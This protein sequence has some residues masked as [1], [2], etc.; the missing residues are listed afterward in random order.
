MKKQKHFVQLKEA[1]WLNTALT[2]VQFAIGILLNSSAVIADGFN[3]LRDSLTISVAITGNHLSF[4]HKKRSS[5]ISGCAATVNT[6]IVLFIIV[7]M[8]VQAF[9]H[10]KDPSKHLAALPIIISGLLSV[11]INGRVAFLVH[12]DSHVAARVAL[13]GLAASIAGGTCV[14][15]LGV[16]TL[17]G[18]NPSSDGVAALV[19]ATISLLAAIITSLS[20]IPIFYHQHI[21][22]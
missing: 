8:F 15:I 5:I 22:L 16:W 10:I 9:E 3:N 13:V 6:L 7:V 11:V 12:K 14:T 4:R 19:I 20:N 2:C 17:V 1:L 21:K 18:A